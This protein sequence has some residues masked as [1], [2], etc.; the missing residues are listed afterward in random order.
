[1]IDYPGMG[2]IREKYERKNVAFAAGSSPSPWPD[3]HQRS[4][5]AF[6]DLNIV[7]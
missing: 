2:F 4:Q 1:M 3:D 6:K 5:E 7:C